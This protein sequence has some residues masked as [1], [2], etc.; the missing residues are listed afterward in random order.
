M[1]TLLRALVALAGLAVPLLLSPRAPADP[2][3][4]AGRVLV[5]D[6]EHLLAGEV[7]RQGDQYCIRAAAS[8]LLLPAAKVLKVCASRDEAFAYVSSRANL[9]DPDERLRLARWCHENGMYAHAVQEAT[10]ALD[11]RP[12]DT[13]AR[14]LLETL[15]RATAAG[16]TAPGPASPPA[17]PVEATAPIDV[18]L[19]SL[20]AFATRVQPILMNTCVKCHS[21]GRGGHFNLTRAYEAGPVNRRAT[22][23]NL[24][25]VLVQVDLEEPALSPL[26]IKAVSAHGNNVQAPIHGQDAPPYRLLREWIDMTKTTNPH[27]W[28]ESSSKKRASAVAPVGPRIDLPA[29]EGKAGPAPKAPSPAPPQTGPVVVSCPAPFE[30]HTPG[31]TSAPR[32]AVVVSSGAPGAPPTRPTPPQAGAPP[33]SADAYDPDDFNQ[34]RPR[35]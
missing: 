5:L 30:G 8:E 25:A 15:K 28:K 26:L 1:Q 31:P 16:A 9:R 24:A 18:G 2:P 14:L 32:T 6:N 34:R 3:T 20:T 17:V 7:E 22:Q 27:L 11:L 23:Q 35:P 33:A 12:G 13:E 4:A 10:A 19:E 21:A 29:Q